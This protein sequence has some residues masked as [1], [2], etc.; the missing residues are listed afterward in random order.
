MLSH[1]HLTDCNQLRPEELGLGLKLC[2]PHPARGAGGVSG[3]ERLPRHCLP[4]QSTHLL[5]RIL[6]DQASDTVTAVHRSAH[7]GNIDWLNTISTYRQQR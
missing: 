4:Q 3:G 2:Q 6:C 5:Q 7:R 1:F